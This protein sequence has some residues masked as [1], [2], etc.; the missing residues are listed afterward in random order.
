MTVNVVAPGPIAETRNVRGT[1]PAGRSEVSAAARQIPAGRFG[2]ARRRR[3]RGAVFRGPEGLVRH[4]TNAVRLRRNF[5]RQHRVLIMGMDRSR[6]NGGL[7]SSAQNPFVWYEFM[8]CDV[9][10]AKKFYGKVVK[11]KFEDVPGIRNDLHAAACRRAANRRHDDDAGAPAQA[12]L[13]PCWATHV[14]VADVDAAAAKVRK[15]GGKI[16]REPTDIP[17]V[18]RSRRSR[19]RRAQIF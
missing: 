9:T 11:W 6:I 8:S 19:T 1:R 14:G 16:H 2:H 18:G 13:K 5:R 3:A 4:R 15:L 10:A 12:G 17:N 7:R